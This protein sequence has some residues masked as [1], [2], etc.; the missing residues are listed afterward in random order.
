MG[1]FQLVNSSNMI[2][3]FVPCTSLIESCRRPNFKC[4]ANPFIQ[5]AN[6]LF[7]NTRPQSRKSCDDEEISPQTG[8][9]KVSTCH[10]APSFQKFSLVMDSRRNFREHRGSHH[11]R[12]PSRTTWGCMCKASDKPF[13]MKVRDQSKGIG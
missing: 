8:K 5:I 6:L 2:Q 4:I 9:S 10:F 11:E 7:Y 13:E 1:C 3:S 12:H